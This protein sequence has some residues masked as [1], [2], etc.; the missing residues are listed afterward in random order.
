[1][2]WRDGGISKKLPSSN[3]STRHFKLTCEPAS[4]DRRESFKIRLTYKDQ[5]HQYFDGSIQ[6]FQTKLIEKMI[7]FLI[8]AESM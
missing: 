2:R 8:S 6:G 5:F 7:S 1:M 4:R 3:K